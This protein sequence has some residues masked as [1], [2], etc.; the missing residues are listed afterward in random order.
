[1][2][3]VVG[4]DFSEASARAVTAATLLAQRSRSALHIV[5]AIELGEDQ[6]LEEPRAAFTR[7]V[8]EVLNRQ[9]ESLR[10]SGLSVDIHVRSAPVDQA[11]L[12]VA[13]QA[14]ARLIV[15]A[16]SQR[17][18]KQ[19]LGSRADR[20]AARAH[21]PVLAVRDSKPFEAWASGERPLRV[22]VGADFSR[23]SDA[24]LGWLNELSQTGPCEV[25]LVHLYW[26]PLQ[27]QR[28]GLSGARS[29][30]DPDVDVTRTLTREFSERVAPLSGLTNVKYRLEPN[31]GRLDARLSSIALEEGADLIVIGSHGR[32]AAGRL[33]EGSVSR[34]LLR[35]AHGSVACVPAPAV[36]EKP[37]AVK[38]ETVLVATDFSDIGNAAIPLAYAVA[39]AGARVH[40]VH[41][42]PGAGDGFELYDIFEES[43]ANA[44][45]CEE[46][47]GRLRALV[48]T[49]TATAAT[50][51]LVH[52]LS[53]R[54][55]A[56]AITQA[57][58]RLDADIICL[59]THGRNAVTRSFLGSQAQA[60]LAHTQRPVLLAHA[61]HV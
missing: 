55:P 32:N 38:V 29:F 13:Q 14:S 26:P 22:L 5:H 56:E 48:P 4:T 24:A 37:K 40:L 15:V 19:A 52:V 20:V 45:A 35:D 50:E 2:S 59:G 61:P 18:A 34:G 10:R 16:A 33:W 58:E 46:A 7:W 41:V 54:D 47:K 43:P 53:S 51:T 11:L 36:A 1:M 39:P 44:R 6:F 3:I 30:L 60:V 8:S 21:V 42:I 17:G 49:D 9:A 12:E 23:T 57:A 28:L 27:F 25:V 31:L